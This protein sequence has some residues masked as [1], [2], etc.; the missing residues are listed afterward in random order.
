[1]TYSFNKD[2]SINGG[3]GWLLIF[4]YTVSPVYIQNWNFRTKIFPSVALAQC[5]TSVLGVFAI[6]IFTHVRGV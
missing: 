2:H 3:Y 4:A 6:D 5:D 1:M